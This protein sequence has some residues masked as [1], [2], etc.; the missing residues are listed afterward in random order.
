MFSPEAFRGHGHALIDALGDWLSRSQERQLEPVMP[1]GDPAALCRAFPADFTPEGDG[2]VLGVIARALAHSTALHT[3]RFVGH[4]VATPIPDA[5]L[6]DLV[7]A[8]S[9]NG[10]AVFEMGPAASAMERAVLSF[11][12]RALGYDDKAGGVLTSGGSL[13][14]L[15]ALLAARQRV[16]DVWHRGLKDAPPLAVVCADG[17][18]YS[19]ARAAHILGLGDR[20]VVTVPTDAALRMDPT[21]L[22]RTL[23]E[24]KAR[25]Q[26]VM[27]VVANAGAT[28]AGS[29]DPLPAIADACAAH[30]AWLHVDGAHGASLALSRTRK[31]LVAGIERADSVVWDAH[32]MLGMPALITAVLFKDAKDGAH[33]FAQQAHYLFDDDDTDDAWADI[34]KRTIECTKRMMSLKLYATLKAYGT[35]AL[36]THVDRLCDLGAAFARIL[37]ERGLETLV[38]PQANIVVFRRHGD[39]GGV[40]AAIRKRLLAQGRFY[41]VQVRV[42]GTLWLRCAFMNPLTTE[43]DLRALADDVLRGP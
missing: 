28:T 11:L 25:G 12:S 20:G 32:K 22:G 1:H 33:A 13:G 3:P 18:H 42:Q 41:L 9:N 6:C 19:I 26:T 39:D 8:L 35:D 4:Q 37:Q 29:F 17:A 43:D 10:M 21:A 14:N 31:Q 34:G 40:V 7:A 2:D 5:A 24:L 27:A 38:E 15:T 23:A 30:G 36:S 16:F